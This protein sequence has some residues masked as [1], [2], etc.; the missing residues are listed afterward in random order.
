ME[1][2]INL[3]GIGENFQH[4]LGIKALANRFNFQE[5]LMEWRKD[6]FK[7]RNACS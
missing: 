2:P 3:I 6:S 4:G 7:Q 1:F 5:Y